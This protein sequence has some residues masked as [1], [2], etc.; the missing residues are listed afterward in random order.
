MLVAAWLYRK[1]WPLAAFG[2]I[3][4]VILI[5]PTSSFV[6]ILDPEA[7][8]RLYLP[9]L[10]LILIALEFLRRLKLQQI[11]WIG[12]AVCVLLSV[13]AYQRNELWGDPVALWADTAAKSPHK[14][15]P[16]FQLAYEYYAAGNCP[17]SA[18]NYEAASKLSPPRFDLL[19][20]WAI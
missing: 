13:L 6:P 3:L 10:G 5:A 20:D 7:E 4:F 1:R 16:R 12:S 19:M 18:V 9:L 15:R 17:Q 11:I 8:R 2:A 14:M